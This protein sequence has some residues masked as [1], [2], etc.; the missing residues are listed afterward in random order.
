MVIISCAR[1]RDEGWLRR[2]IRERELDARLAAEGEAWDLFVDQQ[3]GVRGGGQAITCGLDRRDTL[4]A[5]SLLQ[6]GGMAALQ[7]EMHTLSGRT[8]QPREVPLAGL[9]GSIPQRLTAAAVLLLLEC[10]I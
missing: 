10:E 3:G 7:R 6:E 8:V 1:A 2:L 4:T 5:S 9:H